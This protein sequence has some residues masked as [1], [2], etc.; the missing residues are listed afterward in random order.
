[1]KEIAI[2]GENRHEKATKTRIACRGIILSQDQ[3]LLVHEEAIDQW[4]I[5]GGGLEEGESLEQCCIREMAEETGTIVQPK[6]C[7]L[8]I[9]EY[10]EQWDFVSHYYVCEVLGQTEQNLTDYEAVAGLQAKWLPLSQA[11][12]I[13]A[14]H[15]KYAGTDEM[16]RGAYLREYTALQALPAQP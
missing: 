9:H 7:F 11:L 3:I 5:P 16:R 12:S 8:T 4:M 14:D 6:Q 15:A 13:F 1:M 2:Y 10:Y